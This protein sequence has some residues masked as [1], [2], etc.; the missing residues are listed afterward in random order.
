MRDLKRPIYM[1][2]FDLVKLIENT[3]SKGLLLESFIR[4]N[5]MEP[6][7]FD[8]DR[9]LIRP[10]D[11]DKDLKIGNIVAIMSEDKRHFVVHR[12]RECDFEN[13]KIYEQGDNCDR[14]SYIELVNIKGIVC[15]INETEVG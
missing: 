7:A 1:Y 14:G 13:N 3:L 9:I 12:I 4:G 2:R 8:G 5:S 11:L 6:T 10:I 15:K